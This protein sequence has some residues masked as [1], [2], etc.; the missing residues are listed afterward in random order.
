M[1]ELKGIFFNNGMQGIGTVK[2]DEGGFYVIEGMLQLVIQNTQEGPA[3][4]FQHITP[5][6]DESTIGVDIVVNFSAAFL[7]NVDKAIADAYYESTRRVQPISAIQ[8]R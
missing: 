7:Y 3:T 1:S 5:F 8:L 6:V 4:S 2:L